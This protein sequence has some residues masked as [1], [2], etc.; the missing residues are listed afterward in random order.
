MF[1]TL[2]ASFHQDNIVQ[3]I[4]VQAAARFRLFGYYYRILFESKLRQVKILNSVHINYFIQ[5]YLAEL[6]LSYKE[7][8]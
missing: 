5:G 3:L 2:N 8:G 4:L 7:I 1:G 6:H